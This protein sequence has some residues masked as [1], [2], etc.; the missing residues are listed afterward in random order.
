MITAFLRKA[1]ADRA[2]EGHA[3]ARIIESGQELARAVHRRQEHQHPKRED[4][5]SEADVT[6]EGLM[7]GFKQQDNSPSAAFTLKSGAFQCA[8]LE[9]RGG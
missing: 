9:G 1:S 2:V 4:G 8:A 3:H 6:D 5:Q 7:R